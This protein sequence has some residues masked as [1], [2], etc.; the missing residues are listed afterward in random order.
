[1]IGPL[2]AGGLVWWLSANWP[3]LV[4]GVAVAAI[5]AWGGVGILRDAHRERHAAVHDEPD[6][7]P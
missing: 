4:V 6:A 7:R 3:D 1:M 5:A 2:V